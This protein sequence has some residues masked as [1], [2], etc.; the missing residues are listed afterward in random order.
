M[1]LPTPVTRVSYPKLIAEIIALLRLIE[2]EYT[3]SAF[4]VHFEQYAFAK[5]R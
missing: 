3:L 4:N 5:F 2:T 1:F